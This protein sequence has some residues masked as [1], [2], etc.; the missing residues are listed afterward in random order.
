MTKREHGLRAEFRSIMLVVLLSLL[1]PQRASGGS[2]VYVANIQSDTVSVI[3]GNSVIDNIP[4]VGEP[5]GITIAPDG[6]YAYVGG[7]GIVSVIDAA[8][9]T[10]TGT[11]TV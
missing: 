5:H 8:T 10:V 1:A 3:N 6:K 2:S 9:N 7:N 11:I 4:V